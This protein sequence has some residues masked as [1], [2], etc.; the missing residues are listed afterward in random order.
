MICLEGQQAGLSWITV[1]KKRENYRKAFHQFD[2]VAVAAMNDDDVERLVLDTG[3]IRHRGK[4]QAIIGN[5]R[6]YLTMEQNGEPFSA[7]VWSFVDNEPKVTQAATLAEIPTSTPASDALSKAL[8]NAALSLW[9]PPSV[10]PLCRPAGWSMTTLRTASAIR[11]A[12]MIRKWQS[13]DTAPLLS[14]WLESTTEAHPFIDA[15]YWQANEAVVRDEYLP[16]AE[17]SGLGRKRYPVRFYQR[18]AVPVRGGVVCRPGVH[19]KG[20]QA[21]AAEPRSAALS[22]FNSGGVSEKRAGGEFLSCSG[23]SHRRQRPAG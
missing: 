1:L 3:I 20:D 15:S 14:L 17:T 18:H 11:R 23:F 5:A 16:A 6:A 13:E 9:A 21:R 10:T 4:I 2:P 22:V 12:T 7:F 8:K 19:R